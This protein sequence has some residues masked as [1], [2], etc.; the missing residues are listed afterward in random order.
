[1]PP[2]AVAGPDLG[3]MR[4][5]ELDHAAHSTRWGWTSAGGVSAP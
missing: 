4:A 1:M 3:V 5:A 2:D